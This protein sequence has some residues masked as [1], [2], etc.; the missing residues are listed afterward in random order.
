M[1]KPTLL[2]MAAG[3]GSRYGGLKQIDPMGPNGET[4]LDY[5]VFDALRAGFGKV[6]FIIRPDFEA[7]FRD[8]VAAKFQDHI[9]VEFAFQTLKRL[10]SGFFVPEGREKPWG[11]THAILCARD[12]VNEPFA[13]I[14]ADDFYGQ[15][16][17]AVLARH[18]E[19][20]PSDSHAYS[21]VGFTL[22]NTLSEFGSVTRGVC[23]TDEKGFL[24]EIHELLRIE[25]TAGGARHT[26]EAGVSHELTGDEP[27]SMNM[28][29]FSPYVF[30]Q[31]GTLF[32]EF[33]QEHG[34]ELKSECYIP[35]T[36]GQ[37]IRRKLAT[38]EVLRTDSTWFGV[39]Y[40]EDKPMVQE[41][42]AKLSEAGH[43][44]K[45]LWA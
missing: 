40:R 25:R 31:L 42:L 8:G 2:V 37:L 5:S 1:T 44:P 21:M 19:T 41:S 17:F 13:V 23:K 15:S 11:T 27:V 35:L 29:G 9:P 12:V 10:P 36:V 24:S 39:T 34:K 7:A 43:Y 26:D 33:L 45:K 18:L 28:W 22:K 16:S 32:E 20:L 6:V 30:Q 3:M 14:N 4:I 38:C